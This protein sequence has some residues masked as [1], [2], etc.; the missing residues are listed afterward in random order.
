MDTTKL[1]QKILLEVDCAT[2]MCIIANIQLATRHRRNIGM[3]RWIAETFAR[4]LQ[5]KVIGIMP[6]QAMVFEMGW[7]PDYDISD[8]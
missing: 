3:S 2:A 7:N 8:T 1:T 6:D 4:K 5:E